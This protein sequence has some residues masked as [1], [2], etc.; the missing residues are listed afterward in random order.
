MA[1]RPIWRGH[2]R[3]ALVSCPVALYTA[4]HDRGNIHFNLINPDTGNRIRMIT[5]DAQTDQTLSR[6]DLVKGYEFKKDTYV[7]L[8]DDDFASVKVESS[9]AM[10]IEKFVEAG[11]IDPLYSRSLLSCG[12]ILGPADTMSRLGRV[13]DLQG[14]REASVAVTTTSRS[15]SEVDAHKNRT[16]ARLVDLAKGRPS[17]DGPVSDDD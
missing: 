17:R 13:P 16:L 9:S 8:T 11:S 4:K 15:A 7:I 14:V 10:V 2:L 6:K 12:P 5:Q 1:Q 3:L